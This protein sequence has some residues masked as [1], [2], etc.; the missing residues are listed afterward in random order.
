MAKENREVKNSVL[1]D[2]FYEDESADENDRT[3][4][5]LVPGRQ[6]YK[7]G[8]VKLPK[9]EMEIRCWNL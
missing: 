5:Q 6:R 9:S 1:V 8:I 2:L 4:E 7:R 3:Y